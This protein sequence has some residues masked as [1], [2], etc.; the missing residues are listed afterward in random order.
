MVGT[1]EVVPPPDT[2]TY[3]EFKNKMVS[4]AH[5]SETDDPY[6]GLMN[7][8]ENYKY[9]LYSD[10]TRKP[11]NVKEA[12]ISG[13]TDFRRTPLDYPVNDANIVDE[14]A[15]NVIEENDRSNNVIDENDGPNNVIDENYGPNNVN[16]TLFGGGNLSQEVGKNKKKYKK[17]KTNK[18]R[19]INKKRNTNKK[20]KTNKKRN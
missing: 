11:V 10:K 6:I 15:R 5:L 3:D 8:L 18:K 17:R 2:M 13:Y 9:I 16:R 1:Q 20:R 4:T 19:K 14:L 7:E 12:I